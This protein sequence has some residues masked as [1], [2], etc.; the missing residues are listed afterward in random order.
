MNKKLQ[1]QS[2][3][4]SSNSTFTKS[5]TLLVENSRKTKFLHS[6]SQ[7]QNANLLPFFVYACRLGWKFWKGTFFEKEVRYFHLS[8]EWYFD[9]NTVRSSSISHFTKR[10]FTELERG[11]CI[12]LSLSSD[13]IKGAKRYLF[14]SWKWC[15]QKHQNGTF[16]AVGSDVVKSAKKV[17]F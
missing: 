12:F 17:S 10:W 1:V 13:L 14:C 4:D 15:S 11:S 2:V 5:S 6:F 9:V 7:E 16:F 8:S 3:K